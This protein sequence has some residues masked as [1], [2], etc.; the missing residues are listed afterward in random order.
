[1]P[2]KMLFVFGMLLG[3]G[4]VSV[5]ACVSPEYCYRSCKREKQMELPGCANLPHFIKIALKVLVCQWR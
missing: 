1:M 5:L 3:V 2:L 4:T